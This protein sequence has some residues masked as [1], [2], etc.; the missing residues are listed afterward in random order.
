MKWVP[1]DEIEYHNDTKS[2]Y[3]LKRIINFDEEGKSMVIIKNDNQRD[4]YISFPIKCDKSLSIHL[5]TG[6]GSQ[7]VKTFTN[8]YC[9]KFFTKKCY[10]IINLTNNQVVFKISDGS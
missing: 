8:K 2:E 10:E 7:L 5:S 1:N 4:A 6:G 3:I 9:D